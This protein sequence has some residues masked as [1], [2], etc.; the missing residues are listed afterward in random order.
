[1]TRFQRSVGRSSVAILAPIPAL[2]TSTS[3]RPKRSIAAATTCST[4][5]SSATSSAMAWDGAPP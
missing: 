1:M 2:F 5:A 4:S 3:M